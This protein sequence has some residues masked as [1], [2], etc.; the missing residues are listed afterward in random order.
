MGDLP[1]R[2]DKPGN[3]EIDSNPT[4]VYEGVYAATIYYDD[5]FQQ[6]EWLVTPLLDKT[7]LT[8][9]VLSF[10]AKSDTNWPGATVKVWVLDNTDTPLTNEPLWDLIRD[11]DWVD[12]NYHPVTVD[13]SAFDAV[14]QIRIAW[15][16]VGHGGQSFN[17]RSD[18]A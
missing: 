2:H 10:M 3:G 1:S 4:I 5:N 17:S 12:F 18:Q 6:D 16:Y 7:G 14:D 9:L 15:Q 8:D 13:L 11:E